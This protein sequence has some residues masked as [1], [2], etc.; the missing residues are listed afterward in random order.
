MWSVLYLAVVAAESVAAL[1]ALGQGAPVTAGSPLSGTL[2]K[3]RQT[4]TTRRSLPFMKVVPVFHV[5]HYLIHLNRGPSGQTLW[6]C[7]H[8]DLGR[9]SSHL[10][11]IVHLPILIPVSP[12]VQK[13]TTGLPQSHSS[14]GS[15]KPFPHTGG[16]HSW[17]ENNKGRINIQTIKET[18]LYMWVCIMCECDV[19]SEVCWTDRLL[20]RCLESYG[21]PPRCSQRTSWAG[22]N[23][24]CQS[25]LR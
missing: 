7:C 16:S 6:F 2:L 23:C 20:R 13:L 8:F 10:F 21:T 15:T 11:R 5:T 9:F 4:E 3:D 25:M 22:R 1:G 17:E 24:K 18:H 12:T 19:P 14:P